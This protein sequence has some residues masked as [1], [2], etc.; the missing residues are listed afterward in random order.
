MC[1]K[2]LRKMIKECSH[3]SLCPGQDMKWEPHEYE[4]R[5]LLVISKNQHNNMEDA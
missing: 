2:K 4:S 1:L 5:E 3:D